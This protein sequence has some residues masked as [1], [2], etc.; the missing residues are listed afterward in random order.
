MSFDNNNYTQNT[1]TDN[2]WNG[3]TWSDDSYDDGYQSFDNSS[4]EAYDATA[5]SGMNAINSIAKVNF[6]ENVF[7][8]SFVFMAIALAITA[9]SAWYTSNSPSMLFFLF[10]GGSGFTIMLFAE[11]AIVIAANFAISRNAVV[12]S[13][14]LFTLYSVV[15]GITLS[16]IILVYTETSIAATFFIT[17][18]MFGV[19]A[20][21]GIVTKKNLSSIG[22]ICM[23]AL[24]GIIIASIVNMVF[25]HSSMMELVISIIGV[26]IFVGLIAYDVQKIKSLMRVTTTENITCIALLCALE[27][28]LDFINL[29]LKLI[30][31]FGKRRD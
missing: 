20:I 18:G 9:F 4:F 27:I 19:M 3:S 21:Y 12:P 16:S 31:I 26:I 10:G 29:F 23:M 2:Q 24:W 25:L 15:N 22:S 28:Y 1:S 30:S 11:I 14:I 17:A 5:N 7:A 8:Q 6:E 13:A